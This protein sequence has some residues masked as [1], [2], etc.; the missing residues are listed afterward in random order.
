MYG[1]IKVLAVLMAAIMMASIFPAGAQALP[2]GAISLPGSEEPSGPLPYIPSN[3]SPKNGVTDASINPTL[4]WSGGDANGGNVAYDI[5]LDAGDNTPDTKIA[6]ITSAAKNISY[7]VNNLQYKTTYYWRINARN[8]NGSVMGP[9]WSFTTKEDTVTTI[10]VAIYNVSEMESDPLVSDTKGMEK[11]E[12]TGTGGMERAMLGDDGNGYRFTIDGTTYKFEPHILKA[13]QIA[14]GELISGNYKILLAP[15]DNDYWEDGSAARDG[16]KNFVESGGG[17]IG[18]CGGAAIVCKEYKHPEDSTSIEDS[19]IYLGLVDAI[20]WNTYNWQGN[21]VYFDRHTMFDEANNPETYGVGDWGGIPMEN[22]MKNPVAP[23]ENYKSYSTYNSTNNTVTLRYW[24]GP[25]FDH[26]GD[27]VTGI[28]TYGKEPGNENTTQ[29]H[30]ANGEV[31]TTNIQGEWSIIAQD[32]IDGKGRIVLFGCHPEHLTWDWGEGQVYEGNLGTPKANYTYCYPPPPPG[33]Q[34]NPKNM[35]PPPHKTDKVVQ[36][37]A[38][39]IIEGMLNQN[40][41]PNVPERPNPSN[42]ANNVSINPILSWQCSDPDNDSLTY[43]VYFGTSSNP[44]KVATVTSS[45][46]NPGTLQYDT[47]YYWK[48]IASDGKATTSGP[49]WHF[50]T[51]DNN[52]PNAPYNPHPSDGATGVSV[53]PTLTWQ[54]SDPDGDALEYKISLTEVGSN[55]VSQSSW[56]STNSHTFSNLDYGT[57]YEWKVIARDVHGATTAG[58]AWTF[59]TETQSNHA[60][61]TPSN[62]TP[63]NGATITSGSSSTTDSSSTQTIDSGPVSQQQLTQEAQLTTQSVTASVDSTATDTSSQSSDSQQAISAYTLKLSWNG[64]DPDGDS[65]TYKVYFEGG[66]STPDNLI[67]TTTATT[68]YYSVNLQAGTTY[69]WKVVA[70]DGQLTTTGAVWHFYVSNDSGGSTS[71]S[72]SQQ[73]TTV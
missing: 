65:V 73:T 23:F 17:Y 2:S 55:I 39:W 72:S 24:G 44:P 54:C 61:Y 25:W 3:P 69:Y 15:G 70:D 43:D 26:L 57:T 21:H 1:K 37:C 20:A 16:I 19:S 62:P 13:D 58:P 42:G 30:R 48:I 46:Y 66:D 40:N 14:S 11:W 63:A 71:D 10:K 52:P 22:Y 36:D 8:G 12:Y 53:N 67:A 6:S 5:Y 18:T 51:G 4:S 49:V 31:I 45:S 27:G 32:A 56:F 50:T 28:A 34:P 64:G 29:L 60:P 33:E 47:T 68:I 7:S 59:T 41:P 38:K 9:V 35:L